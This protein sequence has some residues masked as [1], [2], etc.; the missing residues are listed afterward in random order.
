MSRTDL[1][2]DAFTIVRN[3]LMTGK[4]KVDV[5]AS[6]MLKS[7][8]EILKA[9]QYIEE[10][11]VIEDNKQGVLRVYLKYEHGLPA[12]KNISRIS[13][14]GKKTYVGAKDIPQVL[15]G[16]GIAIISTSKGLMTNN[17]AREKGIGGEVVGY[18]W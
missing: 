2:A 13:T 18:I 12:I 1:I 7:I 17:Q 6:N 14:P 16:K 5:P 4:D 11:K 9:E 3:A 15:R 10:F 8:F